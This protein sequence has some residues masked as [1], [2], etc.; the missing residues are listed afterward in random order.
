MGPRLQTQGRH[1]GHSAG[2]Q[3]GACHRLTCSDTEHS[4]QAGSCGRCRG[5]LGHTGK[6]CRHCR[7]DGECLGLEMRLFAVHTRSIAA[8]SVVTAEEALLQV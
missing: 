5:D 3:A 2:T 1:D 7:L 6:V 4:V 8:G